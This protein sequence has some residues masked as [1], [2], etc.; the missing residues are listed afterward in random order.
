MTDRRE[1]LVEWKRKH[2]AEERGRVFDHY[3]RECA[4]CG[5]T[6]QLEV[7][8]IGGGGQRHRDVIPGNGSGSHL[9]RWLIKND[10]PRG[11]Q[12]L[13]RPCNRH[14]GKAGRC[15]LDHSVGAPSYETQADTRNGD[16]RRQYNSRDERVSY[17]TLHRR[18]RDTRGR[19]VEYS[20]THAD[21]ACCGPMQW[22][23]ISGEYQ[24]VED[25]MPLCRYHHRRYD[26][27]VSN[28]RPD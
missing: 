26:Q 28:G 15:W 13:C 17:R 25:F 8:H 19:A 2:Y 12:I 24:G 3:G 9:Y 16:Y 1:Y 14:K 7:D 22:A 4:C 23:N 27:G 11:F 10:F 18:V 5:A 6:E 20:C 21:G